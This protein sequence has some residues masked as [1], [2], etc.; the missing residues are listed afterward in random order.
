[1]IKKIK[2]IPSDPY[3][4]LKIKADSNDADYI[5]EETCFNEDYADEAIKVFNIIMSK[6]MGKHALE[7]YKTMLCELLEHLN[8]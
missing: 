3:Y 6:L 7:N 4:L 2:V 8:K 5:I 1:M